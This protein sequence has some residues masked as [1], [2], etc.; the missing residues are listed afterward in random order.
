[1][2]RMPR[3]SNQWSR[4]GTT[5]ARLER[6]GREMMPMVWNAAGGCMCGVILLQRIFAR[7]EKI[8]LIAFGA[9]EMAGAD[10]QELELSDFAKAA[11]TL[12]D[13]FFVERRVG[14]DAAFGDV[15]AGEFELRFYEDQEIGAGFQEL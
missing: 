3:A 13:G 15:G 5:L 8:F 6:R 12:C 4:P 14:D 11:R 7:V 9:G 2:A 10:G 1:M